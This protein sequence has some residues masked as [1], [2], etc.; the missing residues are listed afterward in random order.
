MFSQNQRGTHKVC[1]TCNKTNTF[2]VVTGQSRGQDVIK[3][4]MLETIVSLYLGNLE[5]IYALEIRLEEERERQDKVIVLKS[6][7]GIT[8]S[9]IRVVH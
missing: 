5:R 2:R 6:V 1:I 9:T 8:A 7:T 3:R 4:R